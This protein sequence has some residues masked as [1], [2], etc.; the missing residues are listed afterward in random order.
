VHIVVAAA[1]HR[2]KRVL[3]CHRAPT[4]R[5]FPEVWDF[6]GGHVEPGEVP[7]DALARELLEEL[8]I[9]VQ[10][11]RPDPLITKVNDQLDLTV[12]V[13]TAWGGLLENRQPA[14]HDDLRWFTQADLADLP[15]A[16]PA[17]LLALRGLLA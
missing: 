17:Y 6:P 5:W 3:L 12:W 11:L 4:R 1:L 2:D 7:V 10:E 8:G 14:E 9:E 16:D 13:C 15:L